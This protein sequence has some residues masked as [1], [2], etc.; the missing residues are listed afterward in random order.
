MVSRMDLLSGLLAF[1]LVREISSL[2]MKPQ[3]TLSLVGVNT[4]LF[5]SSDLQ[6]RLPS[7]TIG[8][9]GLWPG[10]MVKLLR[11]AFKFKLRRWMHLKE[12]FFRCTMY[13]FLHYDFYHLYYNMHSLLWRGVEYE[14]AF[15]SQA[16]LELLAECSLTTTAVHLAGAGALN[17]IGYRSPMRTLSAG[18]SSALFALK[19]VIHAGRQG[20]SP[21][22]FIGV[23]VPRQW[24]PWIEAVLIQ[25]FLPQTS[26]V[27]HISVS[28]C[29]LSRCN[30]V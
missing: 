26:L 1:D 9:S 16:F 5:C 24:Q 2:S 12:L 17:L 19:V 29:N 3:L 18:F 27:G 6:R 8:R 14:L 21:V 13:H 11:V 10:R 28:V 30:T 22:P 25:L 20:L 23:L 15:G 7:L 4:L